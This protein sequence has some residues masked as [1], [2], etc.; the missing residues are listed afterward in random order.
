MSKVDEESLEDT[1]G[2][3]RALDSGTRKARP[4]SFAESPDYSESK[5]A[6]SFDDLSNE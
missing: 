5:P 6:P 4:A 2:K 3:P 1:E